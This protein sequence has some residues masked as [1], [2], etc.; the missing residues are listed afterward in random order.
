MAGSDDGYEADR[1][2][3]V[4]SKAETGSTR[5][6]EVGRNDLAGEIVEMAGGNH[7]HGR[8]ERAT[9]LSMQ[10]ST[11]II[12]RMPSAYNMVHEVTPSYNVQ[13]LHATCLLYSSK[14]AVTSPHALSAPLV[15]QWLDP[16]PLQLNI[17]SVTETSA[18]HDAGH[19]LIPLCPEQS[20]SDCVEL[21]HVGKAAQV[22]P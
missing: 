13:F 2:A 11:T 12:L 7:P 9:A 5:L 20:R 19:A 15:W 17:D 21:I 14:V 4:P 3:G 22:E 10:P 16:L 18:L 1:V 8:V 6:T